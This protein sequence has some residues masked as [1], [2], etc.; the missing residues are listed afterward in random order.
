MSP[1]SELSSNELNIM[2]MEPVNVPHLMEEIS[3][4]M[5]DESDIEEYSDASFGDTFHEVQHSNVESEDYKGA[6]FDD[7]FH[8][9][10]HHQTMEWPNDA[11][12]EFMEIVNR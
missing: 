4:N 9:L 12:R 7:A 10:Y 1:Q 3:Q 5:S 6:S 2:E 11:Y 8:D